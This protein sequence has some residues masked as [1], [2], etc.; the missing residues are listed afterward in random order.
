MTDSR[1]KGKRGEREWAQFCRD[2]GFPEVRRGVQYNG[3]E[4]EDCVNLPGVH[5]EVKRDE[6]L[7]IDEALAQAVRDAADGTVPIV[8]HRKNTERAH[9]RAAQYYRG[10]KVTLR[11]EDYL[12]LLRQVNI[13]ANL[14]EGSD[15][16]QP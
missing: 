13:P 12:A 16:G 2:L 4:G 9:A 1:E 8:A 15:G 7:N 14:P 5:Q 11:A 3:L 6:R 10:W